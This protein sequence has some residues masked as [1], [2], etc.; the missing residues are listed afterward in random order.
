M[1]CIKCGKK[2]EAMPCPSCGFDLRREDFSSVAK[3]SAAQADIRRM[4]RPEE[5]S[6]GIAG[7][8]PEVRA[9][10]TQTHP[11]RRTEPL[12][13]LLP[14]EDTFQIPGKGT[15]P[16]GA[17]IVGTILRGTISRGD[18][19]EVLCRDGQRKKCTVLRIE[20]YR[21]TLDTAGE[22]AAVGLVLRGISKKEI[23][24]AEAAVNPGANPMSRQFHASMYVLKKE[25][26]G[27][28][29]PIFAGYKPYMDFPGATIRGMI[30]FDREKKDRSQL[31][32]TGEK[33]KYLDVMLMPGKMAH[34][35]VEL[36][37]PAAVVPGMQFQ[38]HEG[39]PFLVARGEVTEVP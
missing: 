5:D 9:A 25:E 19:L 10:G 6:R 35:L 15:K 7:N 24:G 2:G 16:G 13:F 8:P 11:G 27:K 38:I 12:K 23:E 4:T 17:A 37:R 3:A 20:Q 22:G 28:D 14:V 36:D 31:T 34:I 18:P 1:R 29:V 30:T 33:R 21:S 26:G 39:T 32:E